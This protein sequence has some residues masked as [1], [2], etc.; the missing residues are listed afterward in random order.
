MKGKDEDPNYKA[1]VNQ[2]NSVL[3]DKFKKSTYK[4]IIG[5]LESLHL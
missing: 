3:Y 2:I 5:T 4:K 1:N